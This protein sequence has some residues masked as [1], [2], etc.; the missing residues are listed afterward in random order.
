MTSRYLWNRRSIALGYRLNTNY[1]RCI[2][3]DDDAQRIIRS[4]VQPTGLDGNHHYG[5]IT[6]Y[7]FNAYTDDGCQNDAFEQRH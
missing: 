4:T 2:P 3:A 6:R 7:R 1:Y 5:I